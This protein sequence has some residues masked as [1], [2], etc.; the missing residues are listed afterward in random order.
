[1]RHRIGASASTGL[2]GTSAPPFIPNNR[3]GSKERDKLIQKCS[4]EACGLFFKSF[5]YCGAG[6][7][8]DEIR[9]GIEPAY[10]Y[11]PLKLIILSPELDD[12][13]LITGRAVGAWASRVI[14]TRRD[15]GDYKKASKF[16]RFVE[17]WHLIL[18]PKPPAPPKGS[19]IDSPA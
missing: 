9:I 12:C 19:S 13:A 1:M 10:Q 15:Y 7:D 11:E 3:S 2:G 5:G 4:K 8:G 6:V 18:F 14:S 16:T 17:K